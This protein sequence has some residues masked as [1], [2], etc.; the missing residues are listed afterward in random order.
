MK[1]SP[2]LVTFFLAGLSFSP[3]SSL[4]MQADGGGPKGS[5][6]LTLEP[7]LGR[8]LREKELRAASSGSY[9]PVQTL[10]PV[11]TRAV[12]QPCPATG[13]AHPDPHPRAQVPDPGRCPMP[14]AGAAPVPPAAP[15]WVGGVGPRL[16]GP[17]LPPSHGGPLPPR[18]LGINV[19]NRSLLPWATQDL[20]S[21]Q[22]QAEKFARYFYFI[23]ISSS[24]T[25]S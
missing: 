1:H 11:P 14:R 4:E 3:S 6:H 12:V 8:G 22:Y 25:I 9:C 5:P 17:A 15:G 20:I 24:S 21:P 16:P 18:S 2:E 10:V 23:S 13:P 7:A 19:G